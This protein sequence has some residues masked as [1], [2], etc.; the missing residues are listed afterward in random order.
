MTEYLLDAVDALTKPTQTKV[1]QWITV[2]GVEKTIATP[3]HHESLLD[4]LEAAIRGVMDGTAG[5]NA[6][7]S[8]TR[9]LLNADALYQFV[10][11][12]NAIREWCRLGGVATKKHPAGNLR[13]WYVARLAHHDLD[14]TWHIAQLEAWART[15]RGIVNPARVME[16]TTACPTCGAD[17]WTD[18][19]GTVYR[20]PVRV[21]YREGPEDDVL[22]HA[23][24]MCRACDMVWLGGHALR[25]LRWQIDEPETKASTA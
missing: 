20:H 19:D 16:I 15:I 25:A 17:T 6:S 24:G 7:T 8:S 5:G 23:R 3:V 10:L 12:E 11:I 13:A 9:S 14:D 1:V 2:D 22:R 21:E 18:A 4:Q